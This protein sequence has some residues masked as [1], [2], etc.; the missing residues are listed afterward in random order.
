MTFSTNSSPIDAVEAVELTRAP[1]SRTLTHVLVVV[2]VEEIVASEAYTFAPDAV[3]EDATEIDADPV[4]VTPS[5]PKS[6]SLY[7]P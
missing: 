7:V 2:A 5:T 3:A 6:A 1:A 4:W